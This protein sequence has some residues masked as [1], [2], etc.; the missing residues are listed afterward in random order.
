MNQT[1]TANLVELSTTQMFYLDSKLA[2]LISRQDNAQGSPK[3]YTAKDVTLFRLAAILRRDKFSFELVREAL[4]TVV[5]N[6]PGDN[7][8]EAGLII[9]N[10]VEKKFQWSP[11][12]GNYQ[13]VAGDINQDLSPFISLPGFLYN[14]KIIAHEVLYKFETET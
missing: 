12:N 8:E 3:K 1:E 11:N 10:S 2:G 4:E 14:V 6:W 5:K 7:P 13:F 9:Y